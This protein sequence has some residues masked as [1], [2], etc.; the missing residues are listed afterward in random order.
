MKLMLLAV[1]SF[2]WSVC[3]PAAERFTTIRVNVAEEK[4]ELFLRDGSGRRFNRFRVSAMS[5]TVPTRSTSTGWFPACI[6]PSCGEAT[7][8]SI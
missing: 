5:F 1:L 3:C 4:I 7:S 2:A 6:R 8:R